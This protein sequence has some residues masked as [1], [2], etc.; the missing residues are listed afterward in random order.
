MLMSLS[1][2]RCIKTALCAG[3][4]VV[5]LAFNPGT[6]SGGRDSE[7]EAS[8]VYRAS[9]RIARVHKETLFPNKQA[10]KQNCLV[11]LESEGLIFHTSKGSKI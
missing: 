7:F 2:D 6:H 5:A 9:S 4:A 11:S 3:W 8:L 1:A 10:S